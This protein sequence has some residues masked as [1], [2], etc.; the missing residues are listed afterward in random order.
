MIPIDDK[1]RVDWNA[2]RAEYIGGG[3]S[4]RKIAAKYGVSPDVL[5][6]KANREHWKDDRDKA[7]SKGIA[8][9]QQK[10]AD[11]IADNAV[12]AADLKKRL[13]L[14]LQRIEERYPFD[15]TEV[16]AK[17]GNNFVV[18]RIRDLTAAY[19]DLTEDLPKPEEDKNGPIYELLWRID[20][21]CGV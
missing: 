4:Q 6:Q 3:I 14:R 16:R 2:I 18:F 15:A 19:K 9:S 8:K 12:I 13:L 17:Q 20:D 1:K 21:E 11:A 7:I 10:S 5:M